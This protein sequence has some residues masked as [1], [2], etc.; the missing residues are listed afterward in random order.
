MELL[1]YHKEGGKGCEVLTMSLI[2]EQLKLLLWV[3]ELIHQ[4]KS[5][6]KSYE[7]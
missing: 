2:P 3:S 1:M 7:N 5:I 6:V 4:R